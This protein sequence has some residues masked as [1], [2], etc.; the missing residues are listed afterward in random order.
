MNVKYWMLLIMT[1]TVLNATWQESGQVLTVPDMENS[2]RFGSS[3]VVGKKYAVIGAPNKEYDGKTVK[4]AAYIY[5]KTGSGSWELMQTLFN[6]SSFDPDPMLHETVDSFGYSVALGEG[7]WI[8]DGPRMGYPPT[9]VVGAPESIVA[10]DG[11]DYHSGLILIYMLNE[12]GVWERKAVFSQRNA[13]KLGESVAVT[14]GQATNWLGQIFF[15]DRVLAGN[16]ED[17]VNAT[18][19]GSASFYDFHDDDWHIVKKVSPTL[20]NGDK[21]G[22]WVSLCR[23][24][25]TI[26]APGKS[27][28]DTSDFIT[29]HPGVGSIYA[30]SSLGSLQIADITH[31]GSITEKNMK[32]GARISCHKDQILV[33]EAKDPE[34]VQDAGAAYLMKKSWDSTTKKYK[35][36]LVQKFSADS[37]LKNYS[38]FGAGSTFDEKHLFV[39]APRKSDPKNLGNEIGAI[40]AYRLNDT[41]SLWNFEKEMLGNSEEVNSF[42]G[43]SMSLEGDTLFVGV[44]NANKV[45][46]YKKYDFSFGPSVIMYLLK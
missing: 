2:A 19:D 26:S 42:F 10:Y 45:R 1:V 20:G 8:Y 9:L 25:A 5:Q 37:S 11:I 4:G 30:Y 27:Q 46:I 44:P 15:Y 12:S 38:Y 17:D 6:P 35:M 23:F 16:P 34:N 3:V 39:S 41:D 18:D 28:I 40:Y 29:I 22:S 21:F 31:P 32:F 33:S 43:Y 14:N 13:G 24:N 7:S 36:E